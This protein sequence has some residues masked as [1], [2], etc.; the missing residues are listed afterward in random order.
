M[1]PR[2]VSR[3]QRMSGT[4]TWTLCCWETKFG[5][6]IGVAPADVRKSAHEQSFKATEFKRCFVSRR[7]P[8]AHVF[9]DGYQ[10][11]LYSAT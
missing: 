7:L 10:R 2:R 3:C 6:G 4:R 9:L 8:D 5:D 1:L 11:Q